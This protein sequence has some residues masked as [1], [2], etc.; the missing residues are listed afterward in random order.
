MTQQGD[1]LLMPSNNDGDMCIEDGTTQM[2]GGLET[3]LYLSMF[4][5]NF[6]DEGLQD[7]T[8][9][10]WGNKLETEEV[11]K[12]RSETENLLKGIPPSSGNLKRIEDAIRRDTQWFISETIASSISILATIPEL[13][14]INIEIQIIAEGEEYEFQFSEN[15]K[16]S[17]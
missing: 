13:N 15:W 3:A 14:K 10:W 7:S 2:T 9:E 16:A 17:R 1:V 6:E 8:K 11:R 12:Y 4:G 5:G